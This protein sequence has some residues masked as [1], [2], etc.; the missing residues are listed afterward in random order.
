MRLPVSLFTF[1]ATPLA[2]NAKSNAGN[3]PQH[4]PDNTFQ[5]VLDKKPGEVLFRGSIILPDWPSA[6]ASHGPSFLAL[7]ASPI[8]PFT[9]QN[10]RQLKP[11]VSKVLFLSG[12]K[13]RD[14]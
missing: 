14:L 7:Q 11:L 6:D 4:Q 13:H 5:L 3:S 2:Q 8:T 10:Q 9:N 1:C 12:E